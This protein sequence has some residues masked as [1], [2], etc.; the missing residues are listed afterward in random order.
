MS[1]T[2]D[3]LLNGFKFSRLSNVF[4]ESRFRIIVLVWQ[5]KPKHFC[6]QWQG[7]FLQLTIVGSEKRLNMW[8]LGG[9]EKEPLIEMTLPHSLKLSM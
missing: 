1:E 8:Y 4:D 9:S 2:R 3:S 7:L 6:T 5:Q